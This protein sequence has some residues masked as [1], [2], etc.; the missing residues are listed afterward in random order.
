MGHKE[1]SADGVSGVVVSSLSLGVFQP[2]LTRQPGSESV[3]HC[4]SVKDLTSPS[5]PTF[6][7]LAPNLSFLICDMGLT[8]S[9]LN[10]DC[11]VQR[12]PFKSHGCGQCS[13]NGDTLWLLGAFG[14]LVTNSCS[15]P[16]RPTLCPVY[17]CCLVSSSPSLGGDRNSRPFWAPFSST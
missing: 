14:V 13:V 7:V 12:G 16:S 5:Q 8:G 11:R 1:L 3:E 15:P 9:P 10:I 6:H 2:Q 17:Y 4:D